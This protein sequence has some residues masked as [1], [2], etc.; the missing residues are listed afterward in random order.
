MTCAARSI[1]H[2]ARSGPGSSNRGRRA[3]LRAAGDAAGADLSGDRDAVL[4]NYVAF[5]LLQNSLDAKIAHFK[6]QAEAKDKEKAYEMLFFL[7][8]AKGD[9]A[10]PRKTPPRQHAE[11]TCLW[12]C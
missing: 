6:K 10:L 11:P 2:L 3:Q 9:V 5:H 7:Y 4:P 12:P 8:R 1:N